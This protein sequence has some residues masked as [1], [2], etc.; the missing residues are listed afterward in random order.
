ML[1]VAYN[2]IISRLFDCIHVV[3]TDN[4]VGDYM[5]YYCEWRC[6]ITA[7]YVTV[8]TYLSPAIHTYVHTYVAARGSGEP[9]HF[10]LR[11]LRMC[12]CCLL[13]QLRGYVSSAR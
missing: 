6:S 9:R 3:A 13:V 10:V 12:Y 5:V 1:Y 4:I 2:M 7:H 8:A 11:T